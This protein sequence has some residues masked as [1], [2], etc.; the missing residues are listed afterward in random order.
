ME[1]S[2]RKKKKKFNAAEWR[3]SSHLG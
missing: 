1:D 2:K 3:F